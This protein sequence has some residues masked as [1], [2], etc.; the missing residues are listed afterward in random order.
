MLEEN[1]MVNLHPVASRFFNREVRRLES[2]NLGV[3]FRQDINNRSGLPRDI[4]PF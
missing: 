3:C 1:N 2:M 4:L